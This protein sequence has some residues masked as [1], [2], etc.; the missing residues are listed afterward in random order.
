[1]GGRPGEP[2]ASLAREGVDATSLRAQ[3]ASESPHG[4]GAPRIMAD[5]PAPVNRTRRIAPDVDLWASATAALAISD[6]VGAGRRERPIDW[7]DTAPRIAY[8]YR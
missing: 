8:L 1:M 6:R 7:L 5:L 3:R 4:D 2:N